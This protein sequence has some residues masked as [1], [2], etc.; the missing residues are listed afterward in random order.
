ML[1]LAENTAMYFEVGEMEAGS[2]LE[3]CK[4]PDSDD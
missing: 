4:E 3:L 1:D 2:E